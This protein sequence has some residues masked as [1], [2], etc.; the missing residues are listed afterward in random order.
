[1]RPA[2]RFRRAQEHSRRRGWRNVQARQHQ[3]EPECPWANRHGRPREPTPAWRRI[4]YAVGSGAVCSH[5]LACPTRRSHHEGPELAPWRA[6]C[7]RWQPLRFSPDHPPPRGHHRRTEQRRG[8]GCVLLPRAAER[9]RD[10]H[11]T[12]LWLRSKGRHLPLPHNHPAPRRENQAIRR[13]HQEIPHGLHRQV[14]WP[15]L[16]GQRPTHKPALE[17]LVFR[18]SSRTPQPSAPRQSCP[19]TCAV[20]GRCI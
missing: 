8:T 4:L 7:R 11:N 16:R 13:L 17:C 19:G 14:Q 12:R 6:L 10:R 3:L 2:R 9:D 18:R 20:A 5:R 15:G 1:M